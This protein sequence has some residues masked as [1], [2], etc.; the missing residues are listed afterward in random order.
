MKKNILLIVI[1]AVVLIAIAC[2]YSIRINIDNKKIK[3]GVTIMPEVGLAK[4]IGGESIEINVLV[5]LGAS[6]ETYEATPKDIADF[7][8]AELYFSLGLPSESAKIFS[9]NK[10]LNEIKLD[11]KVKEIY[12]ERV[13]GDDTR[14]PHIWLSIKRSIVMLEII[15]DEFSKKDPENKDIYEKNMKNY[16][17]KLIELDRIIKKDLEGKEGKSFVVFHPALG[18]FADDYGLTMYALE[19]EGKEVTPRHLT[20]L[21]DLAKKEKIKGLLINEE[22]DNKQGET[23]VKEIKGKIKVIA[24][25]GEDYYD[26]MKKLA[27]AVGEIL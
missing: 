14:D 6:P 21:I 15:K 7:K 23:F 8:D 11:E 9:E 17:N 5:P 3:V 16:V 1:L 27:E 12:H 2:T 18:Y 20:K 13:I 26:M 4:A 10:N 24:T 25:L 19:E 22:V